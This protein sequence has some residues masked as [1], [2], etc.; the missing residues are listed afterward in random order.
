[1][2]SGDIEPRVVVGLDDTAPGLHAVAW[3]ATE[4]AA[5]NGALW[6]VHAA[7]HGADTSSPGCRRRLLDAGRAVAATSHPLLPVSTLQVT[8]EPAAALL[9]AA[10]DAAMLVTGVASTTL[11]DSIL[12]S[13]GLDVLGPASCPVAVVR[14]SDAV[15]GTV[16]V[17][18][19]EP[20]RDNSAV[21]AAAFAA[22]AA[23]HVALTVVY[24]RNRRAAA[25]SDDLHDETR[26]WSLAHPS[27]EVDVRSV[28]GE[29]A[30]VLAEASRGARMLVVGGPSGHGATRALLGST[31][32]SLT[33]NSRCPI[34]VARAPKAAGHRAP[35]RAGMSA[36]PAAPPPPG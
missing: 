25:T 31:T 35:R 28:A 6:I 8:A 18:G 5:R 1:M 30:D 32:R 15:A 36:H 20:D 3:A 4:A 19:V 14:R 24:V 10:E 16:V 26:I 27:V 12:G 23:H 29:P 7:P 22:A 17:A 13:I 21:L 2:S 11:A 9:D 34:V 33:W